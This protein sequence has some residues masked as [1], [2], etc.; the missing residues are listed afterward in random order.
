MADEAKESVELWSFD[1]W[2]RDRCNKQWGH[3]SGD[4]AE[5][6]DKTLE[7]GVYVGSTDYFTNIP[8][9][10]LRALL[11]SQGLH[12]VGEAEVRVLD[13]VDQNC[14]HGGHGNWMRDNLPTLFKA[15]E[16][17]RA[18]KGE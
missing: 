10:V 14:S 1:G 5:I 13:I 6:K 12:I 3:A 17:R 4:S 16:A 9:P 8:L 7:V 2:K 15:N 11:L 18:A